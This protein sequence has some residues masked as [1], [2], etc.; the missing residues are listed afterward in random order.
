MIHAVVDD[1][2]TITVLFNGDGDYSMTLENV[3]DNINNM[4]G[5]RGFSECIILDKNI[6]NIDYDTMPIG[7]VLKELRDRFNPLRE[8]E[9]KKLFLDNIEDDSSFALVIYGDDVENDYVRSIEGGKYLDYY[10]IF[11][12]TKKEFMDYISRKFDIKIEFENVLDGSG[13]TINFIT[14][15]NSLLMPLHLHIGFYPVTED[16]MHLPISIENILY[17][18]NY[19]Y[20]ASSKGE[21]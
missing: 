2:D 14:S 7:F 12:F 18:G 16:I 3:V 13:D 15:G 17:V 8:D 6:D 21:N 9:K 20:K 5:G 19:F 11:I 4:V 10:H 1:N